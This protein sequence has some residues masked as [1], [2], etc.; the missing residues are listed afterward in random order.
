MTAL[1]KNRVQMSVT[2]TPGTGTITL[3]AASSGYQ[4]FSSAYGANATVD[5]LITDGTAWE[6]ARN[7]TYTHSGTTVTRGTLE[8]SSTGSAIS[9]TSA[10]VVSVAATAAFG[11]SVGL[12]EVAITDAAV[13]MAVN[14]LYVGSI[15]GFTADRTYTLPTTAAV[16]DRI[17]VMLTEGDTAYELLIT[18]GTSDT[19]NGVAGG[20]E[21]SRLFIANE[22]V[23]MRCVTADSA[24]I[25]EYDGRIPQTGTMKLT[26]ASDGEAAATFTRPTQCST[27]GVWTVTMNVGG[28]CSAAE[29][30]I[31]PRRGCNA[32]VVVHYA[33][34]DNIADAQ[35]CSAFAGEAYIHMVPGASWAAQ[36]FDARLS[37][38]T[39][40]VAVQFTYRTQ[41]GAL[42][43]G[44]GTYFAIREIL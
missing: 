5:V 14:T 15:A 19:L 44:V 38:L 33:S 24:W 35:Y 31:K 42:G 43:A 3:D 39:V 30:S 1:H 20:T 16:G 29:D 26:T 10:A 25:V 34:K 23:I 7:C 37:V 6:V 4:S 18:A 12:T 22:V 28:I 13:T 17:G 27:A 41:A 32:L 2:G 11:N 21:W 40:D 8:A 36:G 9:L